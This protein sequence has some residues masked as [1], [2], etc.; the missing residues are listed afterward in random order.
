MTTLGS[1]TRRDRLQL[2]KFAC[3]AVW[4][5]LEVSRSEK[6]Y[7]LSLVLRLGLSTAE[8]EKVRDWLEAPPP[9]EEVDPNKIAPEHRR[10]FL[11]AI[12]EAVQADRVVDG[13][14][15]E[16]LRLLRELLQD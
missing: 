5:D 14:E 7:I 11:D 10:L 9:P 8:A 12:E 15:L 6:S 13:P 2:M 4:A 16:S 3:S 1:L